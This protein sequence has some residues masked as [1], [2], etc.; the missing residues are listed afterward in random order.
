MKKLSNI[1]LCEFRSVLR[2]YGLVP[3]RTKGGHEIWDSPA[4]TRTVVFQT[5]NEPVPEYVVKNAI[6]DLGTTR[7]EFLAV[8]ERV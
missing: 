1:T 5:H 8:L 2:E 3:M 4:L 7:E 6:R